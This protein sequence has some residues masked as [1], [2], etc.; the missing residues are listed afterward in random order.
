MFIFI[1]VGPHTKDD[2]FFKCHP[3]TFKFPVWCFQPMTLLR[4]SCNFFSY[5]ES[6]VGWSPI[7]SL[8][9]LIASL[10]EA[11]WF[12]VLLLFSEIILHVLAHFFNGGF[13][14]GGMIML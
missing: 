12:H 6:L 5:S 9:F 4:Y 2:F 8:S 11:A 7:Q 1:A 14:M 10:T 3:F 13:M